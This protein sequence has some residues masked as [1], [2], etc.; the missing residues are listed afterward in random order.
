MTAR[1]CVKVVDKEVT[2]PR[3]LTTR[4]ITP[5]VIKDTWEGP[6]TAILEPCVE[7]DVI[8]FFKCRRW[9]VVITPVVGEI[10]WR[11]RE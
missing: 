10:V 9:V 11:W 3:I 5:E 4:D 8:W 2:V 7:Q 1:V 6:P